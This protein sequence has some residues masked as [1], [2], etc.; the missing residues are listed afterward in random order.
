MKISMAEA[1]RIAAMALWVSISRGDLQGEPF[2][3][4][5]EMLHMKYDIFATERKYFGSFEDKM[6]Y[7][8]EE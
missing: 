4:A 8:E 7:L 5:L 3:S 6:R 1:H 2:D